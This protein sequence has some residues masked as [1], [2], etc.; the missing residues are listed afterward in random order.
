MHFFYPSL[1]DLNE[2]E[3]SIP[4]KTK[5]DN[6]V[7]GTKKIIRKNSRQQGELN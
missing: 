6:P 5:T 7:K 3:N 1:N 4:M 2:Y